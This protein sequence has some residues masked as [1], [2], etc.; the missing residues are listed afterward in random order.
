MKNRKRQKGYVAVTLAASLVFLL[1]FAA[2]AVDLGVLYSART[3]A[4]RVADASCLAAVYSFIVNPAVT[5]E[6]VRA[7]AI[8]AAASN[9]ILGESVVLQEQDVV[10]DMAN[11]RVTVTVHRTAARGNPIGT[12]F[13][14]ALT[15]RSADVRALGTAEAS[16]VAAGDICSKPWFIPNTILSDKDTVC[17]ACDAGEVLLDSNGQFTEWGLAQLELIRTGQR[18]N[19]FVLKPEDPQEALTPSNFFVYDVGSGAKDY[20][21]AIDGCQDATIGCG[22]MLITEPGKM[23]KQDL[24]RVKNLINYPDHD[25]YVNLGEYQTSGG[26]LTESSRSL[27]SA[28]ILDICGQVCPPDKFP[29]GKQPIFVVGFGLFFMDEPQAQGQGASQFDLHAYVINIA[30]CAGANHNTDETGPFSLPIRLVQLNDQ[31]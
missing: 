16:T 5:E 17:E 29:P 10:V 26:A 9:E 23:A 8:A 18:T 31:N 15:I 4:Q 14:R 25:T 20:H 12:F 21:E 30:P 6:R 19:D 27:F 7:Q 11:R 28:P 1:G 22:D 24:D 13:A 3:S 2:L